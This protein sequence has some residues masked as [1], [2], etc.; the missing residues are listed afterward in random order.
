M[1][2]SKLFTGII[3]AATILTLIACGNKE[4]ATS[5]KEG[6]KERIYTIGVVS[7]TAK[8]TWD[9]VAKVVEKDGIKIKLKQF[10]DYNTPNDAL[11]DGSI[12]LN[13]F[14]HIAFMENYNKEKKQDLV[15]IG[16]TFVSPLGLY[17]NKIKD[18]KD[19]KNGDK[20]A[21]P[22]DVTNGGRALQL[23][24]AIQVIKLKDDAPKSPSI[25][26]ID[27]YIKDVK[28][29]ELDASQTAATLPDVTAAVINT[30][31]AVDS[32]LKPKKDAIY[33]DTDNLSKV[34]D[35]YKNIIAVKAE[36]KDNP[37]FA[38]IVK[39]YQTDKTIE[40]SDKESY[41]NDIPAWK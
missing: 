3:A 39:A 19:I 24:D 12:D 27:K 21:I 34:G 25:K 35:I 8:L 37:D 15:S 11:A 6:E 4:K 29:E 28:I 20:I 9:E 23:L 26:D 13:A 41:G 16:Y 7:D 32:G 38:K 14:Q 36:N 18:Y 10:S 2:K 33:L 22:N 31:Y 5:N 30:N 1:K 40:I 17:S